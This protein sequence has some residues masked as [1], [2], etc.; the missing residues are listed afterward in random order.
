MYR[1]YDKKYECWVRENIYLSFNKDL[2]IGK[3]HLFN[4]LK[5]SRTSNDRYIL[6]ESIGLKDVNKK[7]IFEGDIAK[8]EVTNE[9]N[10]TTMLVTG[11]IAYYP[12]HAAYYLFD[13]Q[14]SKYYPITSE[15]AKYMEVIGNTIENKELL[16][17]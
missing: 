3:K 14:N 15:I 1:V 12:D 6:Q 7:Y 17:S 8:V 9:E 13:V 16:P 4:T 11:V 10:K 5:L 2:L